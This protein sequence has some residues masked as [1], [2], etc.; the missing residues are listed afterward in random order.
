[1]RHNTNTEQLAGT[2]SAIEIMGAMR[3][4]RISRLA[5]EKAKP[6]TEQD[7]KL[8]ARLTKELELLREERH[9]LYKGDEKIK[10][11]TLTTYAQEMKEFFVRKKHER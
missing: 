7:K 5:N 10:N 3:A 2:D 6:E 1:M 8:I 9:Q 4:I 11:K